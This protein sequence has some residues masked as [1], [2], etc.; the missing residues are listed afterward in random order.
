M[1]DTT[2]TK[3]PAKTRRAAA[4]KADGGTKPA[5]RRRTKAQDQPAPAPEAAAAPEPQP[6]A[7]PEPQPETAPA[8]EVQPETPDQ[9]ASETAPEPEPEAEPT[10]EA[11]PEPEP[12]PEAGSDLEP[13]AEAEPGPKAA[14]LPGTKVKAPA[15]AKAGFRVDRDAFAHAVAW[16]ARSLPTRPSVPVLAGIRLDL[17][18]GRLKMSSFDYEVAAEATIDVESN[19]IAEL[20]VPGRLLAEIAQ[21]LPEHPVDVKVA[22]VKVVVT[23]GP[24]RFKLTTMPVE[25]YPNL[26]DMPPVSGR[27][28][29][30]QFAAAVAK[31]A[32]A[33]GKDDTLPMLTGIRLE[34]ADGTITLAATDRYR[35]AVGTLK[36]QEGSPGVAATA[37][38]PAKIL[39]AA[40]KTFADAGDVEISLPG[41]E[42]SGL[43]GLSGDG[44]RM[45]TRLLDPEFPNYRALLPTEFTA[46]ADLPTGKFVEAVKRVALVADKE[47]PVRLSFAD[48]QVTIEAGAGDEAEGDEV[49]PVE[50]TGEPTTIAF[51]HAYL[52]EGVAA[53]GSPKVRL[54]VTTPVKPAILGGLTAH[55][56]EVPGGLYL[57]MPI[58]LSS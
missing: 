13:E 1:S 23:C 14:P 43:L 49:L 21:A 51:N 25:D 4:T 24:A 38:V 20:L 47:T 56:E 44:R 15:P 36:W 50:W 34:V 40:A 12:E 16:T 26:P 48:G 55:G 37:M 17:A 39:A 32:V 31:V 54:N 27:V 22:G 2:E 5:P 52:L 57:I 33:A 7:A 35:L 6:E 41:E 30:G 46:H 9:A 18:G 53:S 42:N 11:E 28:N 58:R 19:D 29:G 10:P 3:P 8:A 45:T